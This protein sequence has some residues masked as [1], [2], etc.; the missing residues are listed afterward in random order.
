MRVLVNT[1]FWL[2]I[3]ARQNGC[4]W[5]KQIVYTCFVEFERRLPARWEITWQLATTSYIC[6]F[7]AELSLAKSFERREVGAKIHPIG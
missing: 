5:R 4:F 2:C 7:A 3:G 6:E 1:L